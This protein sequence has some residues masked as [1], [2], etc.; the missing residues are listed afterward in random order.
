[1][2]SH[3]PDRSSDQRFV[4]ADTLETLIAARNLECLRSTSGGVGAVSGSD[5]RIGSDG[6]PLLMPHGM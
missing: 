1:M 2:G 5:M 3:V 4:V 6:L